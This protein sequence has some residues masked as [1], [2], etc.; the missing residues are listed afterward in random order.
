MITALAGFLLFALIILALYAFGVFSTPY[1]E[2]FRFAFYL[3]L[4]LLALTIGLSLIQYPYE[5]YDPTV[6]H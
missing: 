1:L 6:Q 2:A 4:V 3:V 5:G